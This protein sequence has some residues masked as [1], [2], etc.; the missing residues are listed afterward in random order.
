METLS[1][2]TQSF[3]NGF[4]PKKYSCDT[5]NISP[6][7]QIISV[8]TG[9]K[10]LLLV[11]NDI[12]KSNENH[13]IVW[14]IPAS[15]KLIK[16]NEIPENAIIGR[17]DFGLTNYFGPTNDKTDHNYEL[18][19]YALRDFLKFGNNASKE[20][21]LNSIKELIIEEAQIIAHYK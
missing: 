16:E 14:N 12:T 2:S 10:S 20:E 7:V 15:T 9:T 4:I 8:P 13:W 5:Q 21:I 1:I 18:K 3:N 17:N 19:I 11:F 6:Q